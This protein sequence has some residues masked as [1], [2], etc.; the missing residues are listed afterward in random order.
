MDSCKEA[1]SVLTQVEIIDDLVNQLDRGY[2]ES[3]KVREFLRKHYRIG[4]EK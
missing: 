2:I 3:E 4:E 1:K